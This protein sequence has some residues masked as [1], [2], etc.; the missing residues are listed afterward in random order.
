M[1]HP[2]I[3]FLKKKY[4]LDEARRRPFL[5]FGKGLA[6]LLVVVAVAAS[7]FSYKIA[8][9]AESRGFLASIP[10]FRHI[11]NIVSAN[12]QKLKGEEEDRVNILLLGI[13]GAGHDGPQLSDTNM[14]V[15]LRP[16]DKRVALLSIPRDMAVPVPNH[17]TVKINSANAYGEAQEAGEGPALASAVVADVFAQPVH[18]YVRVDFSGFADLIDSLGGIDVEVEQSFMD[19]QY[20]TPGKEDANCGTTETIL[21]ENQQPLEVPTYG[22]RFEVLTFKKGEKHMN[23]QTA[24]KFVRSRHGSNGEGSDFARARRQQLVLDAV[25]RKIFSASTLLNPAKI[26]ALLSTFKANI[27]TDLEPWEILRLANTFG[28]VK[29]EEIISHV[30]DASPTSPLYATSSATGAYILAPKSG[31]WD[32]VRALTAQLFEQEPDLSAASSVSKAAPLQ[33]L[34]RV[35]I[36]NGTPTVGLAGLME[37]VLSP[38]GFAVEGVGNAPSRDHDATLVYVLNNQKADALAVLREL[39]GTVVIIDEN[40]WSTKE[41]NLPTTITRD[42]ARFP[43]LKEQKKVDFV[44]ILGNDAAKRLSTQE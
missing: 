36:E 20:P 2:Q 8:T 41:D 14:L 43:A 3:D 7:A 24:L 42:A 11:T 31:D 4:E 32:A 21:D 28:E 17:G 25:K 29:R 18:Y 19:P 16:S 6:V 30:L 44:V 26:S 15:S 1:D 38:E 10:L 13:G 5:F 23:G 40:G 22:C 35:F 37:N 12:E 27:K 39:T 34:A 33:T 9:T